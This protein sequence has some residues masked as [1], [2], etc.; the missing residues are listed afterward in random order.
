MHSFVPLLWHE[1]RF[2]YFL[3]AINKALIK[4]NPIRPGR[5]SRSPGPR[6]G[7]GGGAEARMPKIK[8]NINRLKWNFACVITTIKAFLMQNLRVIAL[9][10][11]EIQRHKISLGRREQVIKFGYLPSK[12]GLTFKKWVFMSRTVLLD[13]KLTHMSISAIFKQRKIFHFQNFW[14]VSMRKEQQQPPDWSIMLKFG[15]NMS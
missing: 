3:W 13:P 5:F 15:Q 7:G 11:L 8:V 10:V 6:R 9:L 12:T 2:V 14:D 1:F 4:L